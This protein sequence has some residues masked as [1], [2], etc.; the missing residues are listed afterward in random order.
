[1]PS[2]NISD[3]RIAAEAVQRRRIAETTCR[4]VARDGLE[5]ASLRR[6]ARELGGTTGLITHYYPTKESLLEA[7][8]DT[9]LRNLA[10]SYPD[11]YQRPASIDEWVEQFLATL[12][13][14]ETRNTFWRVLAAF[15]TAS[16]NN[17]RLAETARSQGH[18][19][20]PELAALIAQA[21]PDASPDRVE[22]LTEALWLVVDG[23]GVSAALHGPRISQDSLRKMLRGAWRGLLETHTSQEGVN[24]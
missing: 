19:A 12:P 11:D 16:M 20:R 2:T 14:D 8:L 24:Q 3:E 13:S 6:V 17:P 10:R 1:M 5:G 23:I 15:Q 21:L 7:A 4:L 18:R 22:E 9:A